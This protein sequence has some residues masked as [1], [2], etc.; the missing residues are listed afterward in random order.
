M[1]IN[2]TPPVSFG[3]KYRNSCYTSEQK[4]IMRDIRRAALEQGWHDIYTGKPFSTNNP[5]SIEHFVPFSHK[6]K[7]QVQKFI[8]GGFEINGLE[9]IFPTGR[10]GNAIRNDKSIVRTILETPRFLKR[11]L[12]ELEKYRL[13]KSPLVDGKTWAEQLHATLLNNI[14]GLCTSVKSRKMYIHGSF[15]KAKKL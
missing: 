8:E 3:K 12:K 7:P 10:V 6:N 2:I 11:F 4:E 9:N 1:Q 14:E 5:P 13:Y 15:A